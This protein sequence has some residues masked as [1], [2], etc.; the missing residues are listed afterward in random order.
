MSMDRLGMMFSYGVN[1]DFDMLPPAHGR[2]SRTQHARKGYV[3]HH[4]CWTTG[5]GVRELIVGNSHTTAIFRKGEGSPTGEAEQTG[6][7]ARIGGTD[8][9]E[10]GHFIFNFKTPTKNTQSKTVVFFHRLKK[11]V[12]SPIY[13]LCCLNIAL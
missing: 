4:D 13:N 1:K 2:G 10:E 12:F 9:T 11:K 7:V 5:A 6:E 3:W 8:W